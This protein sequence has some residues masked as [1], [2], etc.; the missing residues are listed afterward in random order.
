MKDIHFIWILVG[1]AAI[2]DILTTW[3]GLKNGFVETNPVARSAI[4]IGFESLFVIKLFVVSVIYAL[5]HRIVEGKF[6]YVSPC[7]VLAIWTFAAVYNIFLLS[8][9]F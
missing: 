5:N 3:I 4:D 9:V 8:T 6:R 7:L 1:I 2:A